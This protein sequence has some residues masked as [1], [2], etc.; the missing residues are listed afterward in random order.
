VFGLSGLGRETNVLAAVAALGPAGSADGPPSRARRLGLVALALLPLLGWILILSHWLGSAGAAGA[1]NFSYPFF[2]YF[3][4]WAEIGRTVANGPRWAV[5]GSVLIQTALTVQWLFF[6]L[7]PRWRDPWW[8]VG[9]A[10]AALLVILGT[11]VWENYPGAAARV[12]LPMTLAFNLLVPRGRA[13]LGVLVLGN[14]SVLALPDAL[15]L[16]GRESFTVSGPGQIRL[17]AT[18]GQ[19]VEAVFDQHW[20]PPEKSWLE[21]WRWSPG[22]ATLLWRNPHAFVVTARISFGL[23]ADDRR[24]VVLRQGG[25]EL[26]RGTLEPGMLQRV[27]LPALALAPGDTVWSF[28]TDSPPSPPSRDDPRPV[29]FSVRDLRIDL[30]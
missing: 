28:A 30:R 6:V 2:G 29:A 15:P 20:Y 3:G 23:R 24:N 21:Y 17:E 14:L 22:P 4:K 8:R 12:L 19:P 26:W 18:T 25:R 9:A 7:R 27:A 5:R 11:A 13:W 10:Y 16:P 1:R